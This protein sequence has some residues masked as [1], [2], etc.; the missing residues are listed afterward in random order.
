MRQR[1]RKGEGEL[2]RG[3]IIEAADRLLVE[4]GDEEAVSVR[5]VARA[6]GCTPGALYLHFRDRQQLLFAVCER[7]FTDLDARIAD[8][9]GGADDPIECLRHGGAAY[10]RW[11]V[12]NPEPYR[13]IFMG[14]GDDAVGSAGATAFA[15]L[16]ETAQRAIDTGRVA[17]QDAVLV[18]TGLWSVVHGI[19]S[20]AVSTPHVPALGVE[21]VTT[22]VIENYLA[23]LTAGV[24]TMEG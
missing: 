1:A 22:H 20:L 15:H 19:T 7:Y 24:R 2:L 18:A 12:E 8:A 13:M 17:P 4:S 21:V 11:G 3:E 5:A 23:G 14:R 6:V 10:V 9:V 16:V